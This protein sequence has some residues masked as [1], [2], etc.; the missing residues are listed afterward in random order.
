MIARPAA[1][2]ISGVASRLSSWKPL[3]KVESRYLRCGQAEAR[4]IRSLGG[5]QKVESRDLRR[6]MRVQLS[7]AAEAYSAAAAVHQRWP[8]LPLWKV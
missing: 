3:Q 4:P 8:P 1:S 6:R 7:C 2:T 5:I